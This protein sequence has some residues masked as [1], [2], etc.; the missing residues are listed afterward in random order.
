MTWA[1]CRLDTPQ[2]EAWQFGHVQRRLS[3]DFG[4]RRDKLFMHQDDILFSHCLCMN[5]NDN[6]TSRLDVFYFL[7]T[8]VRVANLI[9][10]RGIFYDIE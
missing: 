5:F 10:K 4:A 7:E 6:R 8:I 3:G 1:I 2:H 9:L